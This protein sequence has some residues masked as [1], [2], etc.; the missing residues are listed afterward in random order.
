[1]LVIA[2]LLPIKCP[3]I[4]SNVIDFLN[5]QG[6][7]DED[8][9]TSIFEFG[10]ILFCTSWNSFYW[11]FGLSICPL[12]I[13]CMIRADLA[14]SSRV[15]GPHDPRFSFAHKKNWVAWTI[16]NERRD[17]RDFLISDYFVFGHGDNVIAI[18][19]EEKKT[20]SWWISLRCPQCMFAR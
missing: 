20:A 5:F 13:D 3:E 16:Q 17:R 15:S 19:E 9:K 11:P 14:I 7:F 12:A 4:I 10:I 2:E 18:D 1:M 6:N 8:R